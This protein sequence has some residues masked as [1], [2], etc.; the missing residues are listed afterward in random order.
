MNSATNIELVETPHGWVARIVGMDD[1]E[2]DPSP[3]PHQALGGVCDLLREFWEAF[4]ALAEPAV[5]E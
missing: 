5:E 2:S 3:T 1:Y 4:S